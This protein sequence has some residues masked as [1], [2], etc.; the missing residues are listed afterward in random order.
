MLLGLTG[1]MYPGD[2]KAQNHVAYKAQL[3]AVQT[4]VDEYQKDKG[5]ILPIKNS[6]QETPIYKKY[7]ID[8]DKLE[9]YLAEPP[10]NAYESGGIFEYVL[11]N[12]EKDPT[13]KVIDLTLVND[14]QEVQR[15][16]NIYRYH[17][18]FSPLAGVITE[19]RFK[20]N[21]EELGYDK[22]PYV[23]S[24]YSGQQLGF[25]LDKNARVHINYLP[26]IYKQVKK[27]GKTF[28]EGE[29]LRKLLVNNFPYVPIDSLPYTM[30]DGEVVFLVK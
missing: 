15:K 8:Y 11:V 17:H 14:V 25:I 24:P 19:N 20:I 4:A 2:K 21:F 12:V 26:D 23:T 27:S 18:Q 3:Q 7:R 5:G 22:P 30:K 10:F 6:T 13:V 9:A 1:C 29:D 16:I 28:K